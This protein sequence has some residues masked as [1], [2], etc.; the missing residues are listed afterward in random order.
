MDIVN[1]LDNL[2]KKMLGERYAAYL[3]RKF[4]NIANEKCQQIDANAPNYESEQEK[5][6]LEFGVESDDVDDN[7]NAKSDS[8]EEFSMEKLEQLASKLEADIGDVSDNEES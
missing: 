1:K 5:M 4:V 7:V 2:K 3:G 8:E 6:D